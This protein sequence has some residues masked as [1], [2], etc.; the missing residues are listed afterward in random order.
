MSGSFARLPVERHALP[1]NLP[2]GSRCPERVR[3]PG[4][5]ADAALRR[6]QALGA[7][8]WGEGLQ[9]V[10]RTL[11]E[12]G[13][14]TV[15][16]SLWQ[17]DDEATRILM[18]SFYENLWTRLLAPS[19]ALRQAQMTLR[20]HPRFSAPYFWAAFTLSGDWR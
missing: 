7:N 2:V 12:A 6:G 16:A 10:R 5:R 20:R 18:T 13:V 4:Q 15:I 19:E 1:G 11:R 3:S 9:S 8:R 17:V 14:Q